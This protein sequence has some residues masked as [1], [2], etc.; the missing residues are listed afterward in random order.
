MGS[1][2]K[3]NPPTEGT[4]I[5]VDANGSV[6]VPDDPI[7][8]YIEGDGIGVDITPATQTV[9]NA[10]V[11][12]AYGGAKEIVWF[13]IYAGERAVDKY[14]ANQWLPEDTHK[15]IREFGVSIKGPLTT[16]VG[17]GIRSLNVA[18]RHDPR[19]VRLR[20]PG[21]LVPGRAVAR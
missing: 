12:K 20:P 6:T 8:P 1:Y 2:E 13:E 7:I 14:G 11:K 3:I 4:K 5:E 18:I 9:V 19:P 21:A 15:A 17:G 10:A 16:P